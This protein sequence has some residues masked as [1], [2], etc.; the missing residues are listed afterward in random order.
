MDIL[1]L[2]P[3]SIKFRGK[4]DYIIMSYKKEESFFNAFDT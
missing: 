1:I 3:L 2:K 4:T